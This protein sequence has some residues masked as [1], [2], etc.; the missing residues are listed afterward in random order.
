MKDRIK[1]EF[2]S[3]KMDDRKDDLMAKLEYVHQVEAPKEK[4]SFTFLYKYVFAL[5]ACLCL[6]LGLSKDDYAYMMS[7]DVNP[8]ITFEMKDDDRV[9]DVVC[10]NDE[11]KQILGD[12]DLK[13]TDIDVAVNAV[14]GSMFRQGYIDE[15][16][17]SILVSIDSKNEETRKTIREKVVQQVSDILAGYSIQ[18]SILSQDFESD[19][20]LEKLA[21]QYGIS[22]GKASVINQ[23]V[24]YDSRYKFEDFISLSINDLNILLHYKNID[25]KT[26]SID[27]IENRHGYLM[28]EDIKQIVLKHSNITQDDI[29]SYQDDLDS[30]DSRLVYSVKMED[31]Y[32]KYDYVINAIS[33]EIIKADVNIKH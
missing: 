5:A 22:V 32:A 2:Q 18:S 11:G 12:M 16:K 24:E 19:M 31:A 26:I 10:H 25:F 23:L 1:K 33:G 27:G 3:I 28:D 13:N 21:E 8:S 30:I 15:A 6:W 9:K 20:H 7:L 14:I 17:N 29:I 4:K